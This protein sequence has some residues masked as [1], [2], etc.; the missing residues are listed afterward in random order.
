LP[1]P[2]NI[3][4]ETRAGLLN[5]S[6]LIP[7]F[8]QTLKNSWSLISPYWGTRGTRVR[9]WS[10]TASVV[11]ASLAQIGADLCQNYWKG[12]LLND[13]A[14]KDSSGF[15][16]MLLL[17]PVVYLGVGGIGA[18]VTL[19]R[20]MLKLDWQRT[21]TT[22]MVDS[23]LGDPGEDTVKPYFEIET[24]QKRID[25][26]DQRL[27]DTVESFTAVTTDVSCG[28][29]LTLM[30]LGTFSHMLWTLSNVHAISI[31]GHTLPQGFLCYAALGYAAVGFLGTKLLGNRL[32]T[33]AERQ[34]RFNGDFRYLLMRIRDHAISIASYSGE[35]I[36]QGIL[37]TAFGKAIANKWDNIKTHTRINLFNSVYQRLGTILPY[38]VAA[39]LYFA[40]TATFGTVTQIGDAFERVQGNMNWFIGQYPT[41][42][43]WS[44]SVARLHEL[45]TEVNRVA[46]MQRQDD[47]KTPPGA[48]APAGD[49]T[50]ADDAAADSLPAPPPSLS[51]GP[52]P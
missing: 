21:M 10:L 42:A 38:A 50:A 45:Q 18:G 14:T 31:M 49:D 40:G 4:P 11:G 9:A 41:L 47:D 52:A 25:N 20:D 36:E 43:G 7:P 13:F 2:G 6:L 23:W 32:A 19:A 16:S 27:T 1:P 33:L 17:A 22:R 8:H 3:T 39:P 26:P 46:T 51:G 34:L 48:Q 44:A 35:R 29:L 37:K 30:S 15:M 12:A 5:D 24:G 28:T